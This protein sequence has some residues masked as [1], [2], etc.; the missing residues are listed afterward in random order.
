[1]PHPQ[2]NEAATYYSSYIDL[3]PEDDILGRLKSQLQDTNTFLAT[4]S[5]EQSLRNYA[6][7]KWTL[8]QV[9][10]HVN[11][12]ERVFLNRAFWFARGFQDALQS[13]DQDVCVAA[14]RANGTTGCQPVGVWPQ[15]CLRY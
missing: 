1:M 4:I 12:G 14:A 15:R 6:A 9:I 13:F 11:D 3:I 8:R 10:N 2:P 7:G 5:D